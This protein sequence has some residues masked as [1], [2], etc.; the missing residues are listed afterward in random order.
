[1]HLPSNV[2]LYKTDM[3]VNHTMP[4][5]CVYLLLRF[6]HRHPNSE[7]S[8]EGVS[9]DDINA[10]N[11]VFDD[12]IPGVLPPSIHQNAL[13]HLERACNDLDLFGL[14]TTENT[15]RVWQPHNLG[16]A[17]V[18]IRL[19]TVPHIASGQ[20]V[21]WDSYDTIIEFE[22]TCLRK[23]FDVKSAAQHAVN[24]TATVKAR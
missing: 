16:K 3:L 8:D 18:W 19:M 17:S 11:S 6:V 20:W 1:L 7:R 12:Q 10:F 22:K 9:R 23:K 15:L 14:Y 5:L 4:L 2:E 21:A 13:K 24:S